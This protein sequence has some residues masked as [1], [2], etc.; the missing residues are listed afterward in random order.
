MGILS[1]HDKIISELQRR[2]TGNADAEQ[3]E[4]SVRASA[5]AEILEIPISE[6]IDE[7]RRMH[8][9]KE[10]ILT[11]DNPVTAPEAGPWISLLQKTN[12]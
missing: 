9:N 8:G 11:Q 2:Q 4:V 7:L 12:S 1:L 6:L 10:I 3:K 5:L